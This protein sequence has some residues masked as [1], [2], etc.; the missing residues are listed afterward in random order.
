MPDQSGR[1]AVVTGANG[2]LGLETALALAGAGAHVVM[3]NRNADKSAAAVERIRRQH[4]GASLE[5]VPCDLSSQRSTRAAAEQIHG[6]HERID[7]LIANAG[8]MAIPRRITD[9]GWEMQLATNHLGHWTFSALLIDRMLDVDDS[10]VVVVTSE[11]HKAGRIDFDDLHG[12]RRY[13]RWKAY[14]Q[15]KLAN[16]LFAR[17]LC[18]RL[19]AGHRATI[20]GAAHP[21]YA[22]TELQTVGP[23]MGGRRGF[24]QLMTL[25]NRLV[26]QPAA[27][28]ALPTLYAATSPSMIS[29]MLIGPDGMFDMRGNPEVVVPSKR[30]QD[31]E[32]GKRLW[33]LSEELTGVSFPI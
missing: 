14:A 8:V 23:K 3:A 11:L 15:S 24:A 32:L 6:A 21:G 22:A 16:V 9:D 5:V 12:D 26:A 17:E 1:T 28:G 10:R 18:R 30:A 19:L 25:G 27:M 7:L 31:V 13:N 4:P 33:A 29:G 2:G 20:S